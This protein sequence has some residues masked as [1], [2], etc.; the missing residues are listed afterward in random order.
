LTI[1]IT[2]CGV[3][4]SVN[5]LRKQAA[6]KTGKNQKKQNRELLA[7]SVPSRFRRALYFA[8][9]TCRGQPK[10]LRTASVQTTN[11]MHYFGAIKQFREMLRIVE[12]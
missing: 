7:E 11:N 10:F 12:C 1:F 3:A 8:T 9:R 5:L 2:S 6:G 4:I